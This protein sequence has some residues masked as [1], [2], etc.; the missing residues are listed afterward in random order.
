[1]N[2]LA[3]N[4]AQIIEFQNSFCSEI[5]QLIECEKDFKN[6]K[7]VGLFQVKSWMGISSE[8]GMSIRNDRL[9]LFRM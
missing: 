2:S 7:D 9:L 6:I 3:D 8:F 1:M 4:V 5:Q